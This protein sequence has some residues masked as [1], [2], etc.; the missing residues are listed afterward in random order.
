M[1]TRK[2][3]RPNDQLAKLRDLA[4]DPEA[5]AAH[6]GT[7][8]DARNGAE[9]IIAALQILTRQPHPPARMALWSLYDQYS[10]RGQQRDPAA[11]T[12]ASI[13]R[14]LR[15]IVMPEDMP[16]LIDVATTYVFPPP[17]FKEEGAVLRS[18]ALAALNEIEDDLARYHAV[19]LL[20]DE[21]TDPMSGEPALTAV[22]VLA[23][24]G[25][26]LPLYFYVMQDG[27]RV[28]PEVVSACLGNLITLRTDLLPD[29]LARFTNDSDDGTTNE[30][31]LVGLFDL[32]LN[33]E[34]G[35]QALDYLKQFLRTNDQLDAYRYLVVTMA[36][37]GN[38]LL[39]DLLMAQAENTTGREKAGILLDGLVLLQSNDPTIQS[40]IATLQSIL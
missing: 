31:I 14:A 22:N 26:I 40:R 15:E 11:Y 34:D 18:A 1:A 25:E 19:R 21:H 27:A 23:S 39:V 38:S 5:Q 32:L 7:L 20:A 33:H 3:K 30:V 8:L 2:R 29:L 4:F 10:G 9:T 6:A 17:Q 37:S 28:M 12:R 24:R 36:T 16:R 13:V 35:P